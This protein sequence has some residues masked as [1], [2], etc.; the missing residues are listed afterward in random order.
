MFLLLH[1]EFAN[2]IVRK[3]LK[4]AQEQWESRFQSI[5]SFQERLD[6]IYEQD[7]KKLEL[8]LQFDLS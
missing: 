4:R 5:E 2:Q 8:N 7:R 6:N 1:L 3:Q